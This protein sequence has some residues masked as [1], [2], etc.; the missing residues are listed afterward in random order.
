MAA[1]RGVQRWV[2]MAKK[3]IEQQSATKV[4]PPVER[5]DAGSHEE[6]IVDQGNWETFPAS[7]APAQHHVDGPECDVIP[8]AGQPVPVEKG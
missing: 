8:A 5:K 4:P 7:D 2:R 1:V 6:T 3:R